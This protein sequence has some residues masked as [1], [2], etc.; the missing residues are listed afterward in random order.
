MDD[1]AVLIN[2]VLYQKEY[3]EERKVYRVTKF[4]GVC[5]YAINTVKL[6]EYRTMSFL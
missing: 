1:G 4:I 6:T 5:Y 3:S 2:I